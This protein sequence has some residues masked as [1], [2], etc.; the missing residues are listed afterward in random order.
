MAH[1]DIERSQR[2][3]DAQIKRFG[4]PAILRSASGGDRMIS[5]MPVQFSALERLGGVSNPSDN[6]ALVSAI[7]PQTGLQLA[8]EPHETEMLVTL[9]MSN[10][11]PVLD[12]AGNVQEEEHYKQFAPPTPIGPVRSTPLYWKLQVRA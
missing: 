5:Y 12:A 10:G 9:K 3:W 1:Y 2:R 7:D 11:V 4:G 8:I 6:K